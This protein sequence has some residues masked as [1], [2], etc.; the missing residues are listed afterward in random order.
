MRTDTREI[1]TVRL[2]AWCKMRLNAIPAAPVLYKGWACH[3]SCAQAAAA[4]EDSN[5]RDLLREESC[6]PEPSLAEV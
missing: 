6:Y 2:C 5:A 3:P 4:E 1:P